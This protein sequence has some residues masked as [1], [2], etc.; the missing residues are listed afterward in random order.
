MGKTKGMGIEAEARAREGARGP[1][2]R[3][4]RLSAI[5]TP[6]AVSGVCSEVVAAGCDC[7]CCISS[8]RCLRSL[9]SCVSPLVMWLLVLVLK[10]WRYSWSLL[11]P[12]C[13][14]TALAT[15]R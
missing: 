13:L 3:L 10:P 15:P 9:A 4:T 8:I 5:V 14:S 11:M 6:A 2:C 12:V 1:V 7:V